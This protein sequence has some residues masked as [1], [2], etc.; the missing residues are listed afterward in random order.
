MTKLEK[1]S[2][3]LGVEVRDDGG[4]RT[5]SG[6]AVVYNSPTEIGWFNEVIAPGAFSDQLGNDI[7]ALVDHDYG[8]VIGRT[9]SG[10]L[11]LSDDSKGLSVEIDVP[12]T[13]DGNDI[14]ELVGRRDISGMSFAFLPTKETWDE[15]VDPP[16]RT[17]LKAEIFEVSCVA[18]PAYPDTEIGRRSLEEWR[19]AN[20]ATTP[21]PAPDTNIEDSAAAPKT[22]AAHTKARLSIGLDLKVRTKS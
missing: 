19:D 20:P 17:I 7:R 10:T 21:E 9:K 1:R 3:A 18:C 2:T 6:Y 11:R 8:R 12:N 13:S 5:L 16:L 15:T 14:W 22:R 4:A